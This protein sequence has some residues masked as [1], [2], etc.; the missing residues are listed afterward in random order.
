MALPSTA[1]GDT[2]QPPAPPGPPAACPEVDEAAGFLTRLDTEL[3]SDEEE[4][5]VGSTDVD[6]QA[7][8]LLDAMY[9]ELDEERVPLAADPEPALDASIGDDRPAHSKAADPAVPINAAPQQLAAQVS[10]QRDEESTA[11]QQEQRQLHRPFQTSPVPQSHVFSTGGEPATAARTGATGFNL[12]NPA[13]VGEALFR[14]ADE[15]RRNEQAQAVASSVADKATGIR[16]RVAG[17]Q[18]GFGDLRSKIEALSSRF[19]SFETRLA[20]VDKDNET[21]FKQGEELEKKQRQLRYIEAADGS[22]AETFDA[23][24]TVGSYSCVGTVAAFGAAGA[25]VSEVPAVV[26]QPALADSDLQNSALIKGSLAIIERGVVPF[27]EKAR[28]AQSAEAVAVIF[29]NTEDKPY[30]PLGMEGDADITIPVMCVKRTDGDAIKALLSQHP[31]AK[32]T[33]S[34]GDAPMVAAGPEEMLTQ[35]FDSC[36]RQTKISM[37][38][39]DWEGAVLNIKRYVE[40]RDTIAESL[41]EEERTLMQA[42]Q[43]LAMAEVMKDLENKL[44]L[45]ML[46]AFSA[47]SEKDDVSAMRVYLDLLSKLGHAKQCVGSYTAHLSSIADIEFSKMESETF[48]AALERLMSSRLGLVVKHRPIIKLLCDAMGSAADFAIELLADIK[49]ISDVKIEEIMTQHSHDVNIVAMHSK[50]APWGFNKAEDGL[51][52]VDDVLNEVALLCQNCVLYNRFFE[53][54]MQSIDAEWRRH[55]RLETGVAQRVQEFAVHY[56]LLEQQYLELGIKLAIKHDVRPKL[57]KLVSGSRDDD[58]DSAEEEDEVESA[59]DPLLAELDKALQKESEPQQKQKPAGRANSHCS[60]MVEQVFVLLHKSCIRAISM[61][62]GTAA[63]MLMH[64]VTSELLA[65]EGQYCNEM[66]KRWR[67][68]D[69]LDDVIINLN[70]MATSGVYMT[71]LKEEIVRN[72]ERL[73]KKDR[74][75]LGHMMGLLDA[76]ADQWKD[77]VNQKMRGADGFIRTT[78]EEF[79]EMEIRHF[80]KVRAAVYTLVPSGELVYEEV[81]KQKEEAE[82]AHAALHSKLDKVL[83]NLKKQLVAECFEAAVEEA[84]IVCAEA[85]EKHAVWGLEK[86]QKNVGDKA[87]AAF[88]WASSMVASSFSGATTDPKKQVRCASRQMWRCLRPY[89]L[90]CRAGMHV[91]ARLSRLGRTVGRRRF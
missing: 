22:Q 20:N 28:R 10:S 62:S 79:F 18:G 54:E 63:T 59:S 55:V 26:T 24:V 58:G 9:A 68:D 69:D 78:G 65:P 43:I 84:A 90:T 72:A 15:L 3:Q 23:D 5:G 25:R 91:C 53:G 87:N 49:R 51:A 75:Q 64:H 89:E 32:A 44:V 41:T 77:E 40:F 33:A 67:R 14:R 4:V 88:S 80:V 56:V 1:S 2:V 21:L 8:G 37:E 17:L 45:S 13:A 6:S 39:K 66:A 31:G 29:L 86:K 85:L 30:V 71:R 57:N 16:Q 83:V 27:V 73:D 60:S 82:A 46:E 12:M 7:N 70:N 76:L 81:V 48:V 74:A 19:E 61:Y 42:E 34:Y 35:F 52:K 38:E 11:R 47:V 50:G 36:I